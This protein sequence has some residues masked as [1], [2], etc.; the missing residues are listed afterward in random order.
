LALNICLCGKIPKEHETMLLKYHHFSLGHKKFIKECQV[1][2]Y[3][4]ENKNE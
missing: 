3:E 2:N 1:C 4:K